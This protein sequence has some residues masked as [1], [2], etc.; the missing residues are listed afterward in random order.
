MKATIDFEES[1]YRRLKVEAARRGRTI[2][3]LVEE[4]VR[5]VLELPAA[6]TTLQGGADPEW[7]GALREYAPNA[8]GEHDLPAIRASIAAGRSK[9]S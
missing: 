9:R 4:G 5:Y 2:R 1:L 8:A 6:G 7:F 3:E